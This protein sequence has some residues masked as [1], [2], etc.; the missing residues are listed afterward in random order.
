MVTSARIG[1]NR[2][3]EALPSNGHGNHADGDGGVEALEGP[4]EKQGMEAAIAEA[5]PITASVLLPKGI[6]WKV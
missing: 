2:K 4:E 6:V 3:T 1:V 5:P